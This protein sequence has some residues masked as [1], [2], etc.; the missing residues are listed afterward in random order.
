[1]SEIV[2]F[3]IDEVELILM[4]SLSERRY[5]PSFAQMFQGEYRKD[6]KD[7]STDGLPINEWPKPEDVD[8]TK[9]PAQFY[10]VK[11]SGAYLMAATEVPLKQENGDNYVTYADGCNPKVDE[12]YYEESRRIFGGDD[13][14]EPLPLGWMIR[15]VQEPRNTTWTGCSSRL[16]RK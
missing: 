11:D 14:A 1:M 3:P 5:T 10:L 7:V 2:L 6:G 15:A 9:V 13:F 12:D 16:T 8:T 4:H